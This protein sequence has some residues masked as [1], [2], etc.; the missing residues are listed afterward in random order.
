LTGSSS[1]IVV[2]GIDIHDA[3]CARSMCMVI[4]LSGSRMGAAAY[5]HKTDTVVWGDQCGG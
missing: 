1:E 4:L 3:V 2:F 5:W